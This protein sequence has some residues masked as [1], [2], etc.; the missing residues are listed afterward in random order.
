MGFRKRYFVLKRIFL[1]ILNLNKRFKFG[2]GGLLLNL[3]AVVS[4]PAQS[5]TNQ[6]FFNEEEQEWISENPTVKASSSTL[7]APFDFE[8]TGLP[9]GLSI[10][11]LN[12]VAQK[13]GL[14]IEYVKYYDF[15]DSLAG[16]NDYPT[17]PIDIG[18]LL[19]KMSV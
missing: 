19:S 16:A 15:A 4:I 10:D 8:R 18:T 12:L 7:Y 6:I 3:T 2:I 1:T 11:Y 5:P 17:K 9:A 13:V 14:K